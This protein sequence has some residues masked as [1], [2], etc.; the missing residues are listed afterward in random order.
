MSEFT[1]PQRITMEAGK[2]IL[3][4]VDP[5]MKKD[6]KLAELVSTGAKRTC[7]T[8]GRY[9]LYVISTL[10][11]FQSLLEKTINWWQHL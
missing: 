6:I 4:V 3:K 9:H 1:E 8:C 10:K 5:I 7:I 2:T 11:T